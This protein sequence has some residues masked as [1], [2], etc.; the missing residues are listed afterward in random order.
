MSMTLQ[1]NLTQLITINLQNADLPSN[2]SV[3][4]LEGQEFPDLEYSIGYENM[5]HGDFGISPWEDT[6][7]RMDWTKNYVKFYIGDHL[8]RTIT[9]K[10]DE[11][12]FSTPS[13][14]YLRH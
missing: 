10:D 2:A 9:R 12:L 6:V 3:S 1:Y 4:M 5:T 8:A 13:P 11:G 14:L 7:F